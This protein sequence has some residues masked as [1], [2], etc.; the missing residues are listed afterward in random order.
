MPLVAPLISFAAFFAAFPA[1]P[2][3]VPALSADSATPSI[4]AA[5]T[6]APPPPD[7]F[8]ANISVMDLKALARLISL[9]IMRLIT[10]ITG[11]STLMSPWPIVAFKLSN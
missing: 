10:L 4:P 5:A 8:P 2:M 1:P 7:F 11:V 3:A 9:L 6:A